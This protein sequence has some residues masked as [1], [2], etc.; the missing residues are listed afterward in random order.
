MLTFLNWF[1]WLQGFAIDL[2]LVGT[3]G[4]AWVMHGLVNQEFNRIEPFREG[5]LSWQTEPSPPVAV[6]HD[7]KTEP[8]PQPACP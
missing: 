6:R 3:I 1:F 7:F 5:G 8:Y 2:A 4:W